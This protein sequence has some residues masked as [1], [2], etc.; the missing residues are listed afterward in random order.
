MSMHRTYVFCFIR[1]ILMNNRGL[2]RQRNSGRWSLQISLLPD[3]ARTLKSRWL[4]LRPGSFDQMLTRARFEEAKLRDLSNNETRPLSKSLS[5]PGSRAVTEEP[6]ST[7]VSSKQ[8][9]VTTPRFNVGGQRTSGRCFNC[10]S[11]MHLIRRYPYITRPRAT[12]TSGPGIAGQLTNRGCVSSVIPSGIPSD[13][14]QK[15]MD[16]KKEM[17]LAD[18]EEQSK[19]DLELEKEK[20]ITQGESGENSIEDDIHKLFVTMHGVT[21]IDPVDNV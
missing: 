6:G 4:V 13:N 3:F 11:P 15:I 19:G 12:E 1:L 17:E 9:K 2:K 18:R 14:H 8:Q 10:G 16:H 5:V 7:S 21:S 20:E